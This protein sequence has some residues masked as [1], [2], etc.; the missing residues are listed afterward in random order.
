M[1]FI[2]RG[3]SGN[4]IIQSTEDYMGKENEKPHVENAVNGKARFYLC[5]GNIKFPIQY[6]WKGGAMMDNLSFHVEMPL[7]IDQA[8]TRGENGEEG[9]G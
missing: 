3:A 8:D 2:R 1:K 4:T 9:E 7:D 6:R 5:K